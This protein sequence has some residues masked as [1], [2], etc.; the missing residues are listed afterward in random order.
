MHSLPPPSPPP[1]QSQLQG[2]HEEPGAQAGQA[3]A[4][5]LPPPGVPAPSVCWQ[6]PETQVLPVS[7]DRPSGNHTQVSVVSARHDASSVFSLHGSTGAMPPSEA[8][9][10]QGGQFS[11]P[12]AVISQ[13]IAG[14][15]QMEAVLG[16]EPLVVSDPDD[17]DVSPVVTPPEAQLHSGAGH[18]SPA[19]QGALEQTQVP[20]VT[21]PLPEPPPPLQ[22][23]SHG[24]QVCPASQGAHEQVQLPPPEPPPEQSHSV[25]G[26]ALPAGQYI[27]LAQLHPPP[28]GEVSWQ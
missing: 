12:S 2:W 27:G 17:T 10:S 9:Q 23:Q 28:E 25:G 16:D 21:Q 8:P 1:E 19:V 6:T 4:Q 15:T 22:S 7:H 18:F 13:A 14:H 26:H 20:P 24:A 3:H 11:P 5:P